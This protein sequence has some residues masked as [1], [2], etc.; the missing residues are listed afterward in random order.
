MRKMEQKININ[1]YPGHMAKARRALEEKLKKIDI[2][3]EVLD[4]RAP[5]YTKNPD[6][7]DLFAPKGR[8]YLLNKEDMADPEITKEWVRYFE[9]QEIKH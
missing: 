4:A 2:V 6:F 5:L 3:V 7:D 8:M 9:K 1:W